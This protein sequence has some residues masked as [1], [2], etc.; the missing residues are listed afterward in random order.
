VVNASL[1]SGAA[2]QAE[3]DAIAASPNTL[4][5][6]AAGNGDANGVG[7]D[8]DQTPDYPCAYPLDNIVCVAATDSSD[9][10]APFSNFGTV[11]VDIAAPGVSVASDFPVSLGSY[12]YLDG[13][14]MATPH[15]SGVAALVGSQ[16]P[17]ATVADLRAALL[18]GADH[19]PALAGKI[20]T[21]ARLNA[22]GALTGQAPPADTTPAPPADT[23]PDDP[24]PDEP[25]DDEPGDDTSEPD[26]PAAD[27][28]APIV[29]V[30]IA[31]RAS[32]TSLR[33]GLSVT[34]SCS[35]ACKIEASLVGRRTARSSSLGHATRVLNSA[36]RAKVKV[37]PTRGVLRKWSRIA[38]AG[39][40][41]SLH[42]S[43][44]DQAGNVRRV[45]KAIRVTR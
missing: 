23:A 31:A 41:L 35:E 29:S 45:V 13:T 4:F 15:V 44:H 1:G 24:A 7:Q 26:T 40:R 42:L 6:V 30:K 5:V 43:A 3:S 28:T 20:A 16:L 32:A 36:G 22:Y 12:M 37:R 25:V 19:P 9:Q 38:R 34:V 17:D 2:S 18:T 39:K 21:G 14:S 10:L 11:G 33:R 27:T 8:V